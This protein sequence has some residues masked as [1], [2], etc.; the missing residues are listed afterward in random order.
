MVSFCPVTAQMMDKAE[1]DALAYLDLLALH[2]ER[3]RTN[4]V[5]EHT[6]RKIK[7]QG[8]CG[9]GIPKRYITYSLV[10]MARIERN[11]MRTLSWL[12]PSKTND[13][14]IADTI[15]F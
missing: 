12:Q 14:N 9:A 15:A 4:N 13:I 8:M 10:G 6:N 2:W 11:P 3:L 1:V 7:T 5:Q